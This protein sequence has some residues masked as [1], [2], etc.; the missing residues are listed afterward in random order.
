MNQKVVKSKT[1]AVVASLAKVD[2]PSESGQGDGA[3]LAGEEKENIITPMLLAGLT[4]TATR[5]MK[6]ART[7]ADTK[8]K[9]EVIIHCGSGG[10]GDF[11]P[12]LKNKARMKLEV[13]L[14]VV[15]YSRSTV[16]DSVHMGDPAGGYVVML[17][18]RNSARE[19]LMAWSEKHA[20]QEYLRDLAEDSNLYRKEYGTVM[21]SEANEIGLESLLE[22]FWRAALQRY[23][24]ETMHAPAKVA[25]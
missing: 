9:M 12:S 5:S 6:I 17:K 18:T 25:A 14:G 15:E 8:L 23:F 24:D 22:V 16:P 10:L 4:S 3:A 2:R 7:L 21:S 20:I 11:K 13:Q 19:H 1:N